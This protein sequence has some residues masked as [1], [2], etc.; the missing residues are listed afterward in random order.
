[1]GSFGGT[2]GEHPLPL[3]EGETDMPSATQNSATVAVEDWKRSIRS[4]HQ[5]R[6]AAGSRRERTINATGD[7]SGGATGS[8]MGETSGGAKPPPK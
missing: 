4:A 2:G 8:D 6:V 7:T 1:M 5:R 3:V